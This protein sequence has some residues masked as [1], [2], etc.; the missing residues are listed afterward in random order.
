MAVA[1]CN[2][3]AHNARQPELRFADGKFKI[4]QLTDLHW[5]EDAANCDTTEATIRAVVEAE[6]PGLIMLTGDVVTY[7]PATDGW[8]HI[9]DILYSLQVPFTVNLGNHDAEYLS[10]DSIFNL[11]MKSP[12]YV[13][14]KGPTTLHGLG[15]TALPILGADGTVAAVVYSLDSGDDAPDPTLGKYDWIRFNQIK[16]YRNASDRFAAANDGEPLPSIMFFHIPIPEYGALMGDENTFGCAKEGAGAP[17]A[18]NSGLFASLIEQGDVMGVFTGHD[19]ENDYVGLTRGIALGFGRCTGTQAYGDAVRGG[20]II[21]LYEGEHRF[22]THIVTPEG[23]EPAWHYP[24][25]LNDVQADT[26]TYHPAIEHADTTRGVAFNYYEG[27]IKH[28]SQIADA[29]FR[30]S[31]V[32][33]NFDI[34]GAPADDHFA[35]RFRSV[36]RIPERGVY[37]FHTYS[38]DGSVVRID[39]RTIVDNDGGHST[40]YR[41]GL[42]ALEPGFHSLDVDYFEDYMGQELNVGITSL[43]IPTTLIPDS[44]LYLPR[45]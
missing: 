43:A 31:G 11:V 22:D 36:I 23:V 28:T 6:R 1:G 12:Y 24:S 8:N 17:S 20:R 37:R 29:M 21:E 30:S 3:T 26:M 15:N 7:E 10:R 35:Y 5:K 40:R 16:W 19:H 4:L 9:V 45:Q 27:R 41:E 33:P 25:A 32:L 38:D 34:T 44:L 2:D 18:I 13:G 42:V 39:G 14:D